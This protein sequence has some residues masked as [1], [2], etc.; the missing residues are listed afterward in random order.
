[1]PEQLSEFSIPAKRILEAAPEIIPET[2][3]PYV[4]KEVEL[5]GQKYRYERVAT[6]KTKWDEETQ[7]EVPVYYSLKTWFSHTTPG[8]GP[9]PG[10]DSKQRLQGLTS[11]AMLER[12]GHAFTRDE[13]FSPSGV[14]S[15]MTGEF[16]G[17]M[18]DDIAYYALTP[19]E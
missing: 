6:S 14:Q 15:L 13:I 8:I 1:M 9:G 2:S 7:T 10:W 17:G 19:I 5:D 11:E 12:Y 3:L 16:E 18:P 4:G